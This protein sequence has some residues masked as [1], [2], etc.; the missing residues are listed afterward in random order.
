MEHNVGIFA[1]IKSWHVALVIQLVENF[2]L[3]DIG[4]LISELPILEHDLFFTQ[5]SSTLSG[6]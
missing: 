6:K 3:I 2:K 5:N 1:W 4:Y